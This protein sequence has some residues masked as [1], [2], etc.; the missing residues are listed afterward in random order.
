MYMFG[1]SRIIK[2][3]CLLGSFVISIY[4]LGLQ[5]Y[6]HGDTMAS[7]SYK[8]ES[9]SMN[10][11]GTRSTSNTYIIE[12][13]LG[14]IATGMSS[15]TN[16]VLKAGYQQMHDVYLA[17]T[18]ASDVTMSPSLGG[19][20][21]GTSNGATSFSV[22][23]D[24]QAGYTVTI[25]ASSSPALRSGSDTFSDYSPA[26]A[27]PDFT[28]TNAAN[29]SSFAF[30]P[31]GDDIS[32]RFKD[33]GAACNAGSGDTGTSCWDGLSITPKTIV[34][35]TSSNHPLGETTTI[36]FRAATGSSFIQPDGTYTATTTITILP[37]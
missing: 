36:R 7:P 14:E 19:V 31:E 2:V 6:V 16:F 4:I 25:K 28:F 11:G 5:T 15:S 34:S 30:S 35:R 8:I 32:Q 37:L 33:N 23:T 26:G 13:T 12:D 18:P 10:F 3:A 24:N 1:N 21:G 17:I 27:D 20:V 9:D 22:N 29:T